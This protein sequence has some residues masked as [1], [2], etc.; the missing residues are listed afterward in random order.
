MEINQ[1]GRSTIMLPVV[2][3]RAIHRLPIPDRGAIIYVGHA[4][5][6]IISSGSAIDLSPREE[7]A[8]RSDAARGRKGSRDMID[9]GRSW[10]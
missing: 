4:I 5:A 6:D 9:E 1:S 2:I 10:E 8:V 7:A 3:G